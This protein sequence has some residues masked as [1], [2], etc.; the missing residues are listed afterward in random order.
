MNMVFLESLV[1]ALVRS[2]SQT[3]SPGQGFYFMFMSLGVILQLVF[4][5]VFFLIWVGMFLF[6]IAAMAVCIISYWKIFT[7]AGQPGYAA[8]IPYYNLYVLAEMCFGKGIYCLFV[9]A[10]FL[11]GIGSL[12]MAAYMIYQSYQLGRV[13]NKSVGFTI[14]LIF[15]PIV[16]LPMLALGKDEYDPDKVS[17]LF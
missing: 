3:T 7:K 5:L 17:F 9:L 16:F 15:V 1:S 4:M 10:G 2:G 11:P 14:G 12:V 6:V 8:I 13:F